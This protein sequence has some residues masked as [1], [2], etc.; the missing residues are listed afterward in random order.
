MDFS[1][2]LSMQAELSLLAV[3]VILFIADLF[4][5]GDGKEQ[6]GI[7][8][9]PLPI[10]LLAA[11][12]LLNLVPTLSGDAATTAFGGMYVT[13]AMG[14]IVKVGAQHRHA[15]HLLHGAW[16]DETSREFGETR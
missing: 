12:T 4:M 8:N 11:H 3:I 5:S 16:V 7:Y 14:G 10:I 9:T 15:H 6:K 13:T 1:Q 2:F